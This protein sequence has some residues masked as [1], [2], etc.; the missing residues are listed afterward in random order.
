MKVK[1][2]CFAPA[3]LLVPVLMLLAQSQQEKERLVGVL[4]LNPAMTVAEI[5]AGDGEVSFFVAGKVSRMYVNEIDSGKLRK[6]RDR[7]A[8]V[9]NVTVVEGDATDTRLP[10][11]CCDVVVMRDVY[12]HLTASAAINASIARALKPGGVFMVIDFLPGNEGHGITREKLVEGVTRAG[13]E[14]I[15]TI[16]DWQFRS[17]CVLFRKNIDCD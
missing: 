6:L 13:L 8:D 2:Y 14:L 1:F 3:T 12:H 11:G 9:A 15:R 5:G 10:E 4:E 7:A 16:D 17:Y